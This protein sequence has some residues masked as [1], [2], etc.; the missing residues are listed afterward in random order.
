MVKTFFF[1]GPFVVVMNLQFQISFDTPLTCR[2]GVV[3]PHSTA[4]EDD[5]LESRA[6]VAYATASQPCPT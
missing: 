1:G 5:S 2:L 4:E 3:D 6:T